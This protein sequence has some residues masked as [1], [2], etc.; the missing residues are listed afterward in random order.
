MN[1]TNFYKNVFKVVSLMQIRKIWN[2][3]GRERHSQ[4]QKSY[5]CLPHGYELNDE[6]LEFSK[7][8]KILPISTL[9]NNK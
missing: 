1:W 6:V 2:T 4:E 3:V 8:N 5:V 9:I 7:T